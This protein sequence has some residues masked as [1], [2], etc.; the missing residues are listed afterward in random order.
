MTDDRSLLQRIAA[1]A[2]VDYGLEPEFPQDAVSEV[3]DLGEA[4]VSGLRDLRD[5]PWSSIDNDD[6]RDLD[7]LEVT[8]E[9]RGVTRV[10]VAIADVD[11]LVTKGCA[12]DD[13]ARTNTT[14]V[15]TV[16]RVFPML[17]VELSTDR[18]S[19]NDGEDR[20]ALVA[21][22]RI[23]ADGSILGGEVYRAAVRNHARLTYDGVA[24]WLDGRTPPPAALASLAGLEPQLR[25]QD[26]LG[27]VM[28]EQRQRAGALEFD[29]NEVKPI[30]DDQGAVY[31][32]R[33]DL[34]NRARDIIESF[35]VAANGVTAQFLTAHGWAS[36]R[37]VVR[38]PKR[39]PRIV[40]IAA[41]L[42][43]TLPAEPDSQALET[44]LKARRAA[45]PEGFPDLSVSILKLMGRGEYVADGP[46]GVEDGHFALAQSNY[47][48]S[49]APNRRFPDLVTQRL[50]KAALAGGRPP[51][52]LADLSTLAAHCTTQEDA[53]NKVERRVR[54]S[55][56]ALLLAHRIGQTFD[57]V[58]TG[59]SDK[60][61]W[62]RLLT[63]PV[64]GKLEK[65]TEGLDVGDRLRVRLLRTDAE[66]GFV[67]FGRA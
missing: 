18:T 41:A 10:L 39:W 9:E 3:R 15:Y 22:M 35:M 54:K 58:V 67:D 25:T 44:F 6:S 5:L 29:R 19:L 48:H 47:T 14:S 13:H 46:G 23:G 56:A 36:I 24:A 26:R 62:V 53:A 17:P 2:M 28:R 7:Q 16:A 8:I 4:P 37:R 11:S 64:E 60:G 12:L 52:S 1:R 66:R 38:V 40:D 43:T 59:A 33:P 32:L 57:A 45:D 49:T 27:A 42:G 31:E 51:Y 34:T 61:T 55:A 20:P 63:P 21:D 50:V 30:L 65:G